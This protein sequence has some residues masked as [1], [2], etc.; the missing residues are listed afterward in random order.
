LVPYTLGI[1]KKEDRIGRNSLSDGKH[2]AWT[3]RSRILAKNFGEGGFS[4]IIAPLQSADEIPNENGRWIV[5]SNRADTHLSDSA[6]WIGRS[7]SQQW[8]TNPPRRFNDRAKFF[9]GTNHEKTSLSKK[10]DWDKARRRE[11]CGIRFS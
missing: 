5:L 2:I 3:E 11:D 7:N 8:R 6:R 1:Q 4:G 10:T 9:C